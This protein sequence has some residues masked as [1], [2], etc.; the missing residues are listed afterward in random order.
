MIFDSGL[1]SVRPARSCNMVAPISVLETFLLRE[2]RTVEGPRRNSN[3][4][5]TMIPDVYELEYN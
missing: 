2:G 1:P 3:L 4:Y 5:C